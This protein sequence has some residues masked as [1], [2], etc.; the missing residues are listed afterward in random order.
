MTLGGGSVY[1]DIAAGIADKIY[2]GQYAAGTYLPSEGDLAAEHGVGRDTIRRSIGTLR[3]WGLVETS[4]G[5][6]S[7]VVDLSDRRT[8][9]EPAGTR[10]AA[11][12]AGPRELRILSGGG[13]NLD[14]V[15]QGWP[16]LVV[17]RPDGSGDLYPS[18][19]VEVV[20]GDASA[21]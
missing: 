13:W 7:R 8:V 1:G 10:V 3:R 19:Q 17:S 15:R 4:R 14:L 18:D 11:I 21:E 20:V 12:P 5:E 6:R 16:V 2:N 9:H